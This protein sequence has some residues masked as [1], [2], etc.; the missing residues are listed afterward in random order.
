LFVFQSLFRELGTEDASDQETELFIQKSIKD[1]AQ[2]VRIHAQL[3]EHPNIIRLRGVCFDGK[4]RPKYIL[5]ELAQF[6]SLTRFL[7]CLG[8]HISLVEY[9]CLLADA[10]EGLTFLHEQALPVSV[11]HHDIKPANLFVCGSVGFAGRVILKLGDFGCATF[12][13]TCETDEHKRGTIGFLAPELAKG[14]RHDA[15]VDVYSFG[16]SMLLVAAKHLEEIT[17]CA[18]FE[19][20]DIAAYVSRAKV[21]LGTL[22]PGIS[23]LLRS[24]VED[25]PHRRLSARGALSQLR[26][27]MG[28]DFAKAL[29]TTALPKEAAMTYDVSDSVRATK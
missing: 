9:T 19:D 22:A 20:L 29:T 12:G 16:I 26:E 24:C 15:Q 27:I 25:E 23:G 17:D 11:V 28:P 14:E 2:E 18:S 13:T 1:I 8:R 5:V 10:L 4:H 7:S 6:F 3:S 21:G